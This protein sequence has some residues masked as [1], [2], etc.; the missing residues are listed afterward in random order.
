M[1]D[2]LILL[3]TAILAKEKGFDEQSYR[4]FYKETLI[5]SDESNSNK[6]N[7]INVYSAPTQSLLQRWL[8]ESHNV[9]IEVKRAGSSPIEG[10]TKREKKFLTIIL[11]GHDMSP[12]PLQIDGNYGNG[13][14]FMDSYEQALEHGLIEALKQ[15]KL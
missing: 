11:M 9:F 4:L 7:E 15:L 14:L 1:R 6:F 13:T 3:K 10:T 2:E 8:R 12:Y 5:P